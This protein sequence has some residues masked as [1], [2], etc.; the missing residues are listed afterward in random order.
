M[1][2]R[3]KISNFPYR[4]GFPFQGNVIEQHRHTYG[5]HTAFG[6][7]TAWKDGTRSATVCNSKT[8]IEALRTCR[9][10]IKDFNGG[11]L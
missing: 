7:R 9:A 5:A 10:Y 11:P 6:K 1:K 8:R 3:I 4:K 2:F